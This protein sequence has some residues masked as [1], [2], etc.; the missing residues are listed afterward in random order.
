LL[1]HQPLDNLFNYLLLP[2]QQ[3]LKKTKLVENLKQLLTTNATNCKLSTH[4][5]RQTK[6]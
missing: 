4:L 5:T 3:T 2:K 6:H 1:K